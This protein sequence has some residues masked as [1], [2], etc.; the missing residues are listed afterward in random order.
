MTAISA[1][2]SGDQQKYVD[3]IFSV[4]VC[5]LF[6]A[7]IFPRPGAA[8]QVYSVRVLLLRS[9]AGGIPSARPLGLVL[10]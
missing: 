8:V 9:I 3:K 1:P 7:L 5:V 2:E 6:L 4:A 10:R